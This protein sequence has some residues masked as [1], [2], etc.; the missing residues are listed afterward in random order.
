[1]VGV[2]GLGGNMNDQQTS[3]EIVDAL[4]AVLNCPRDV[5]ELAVMTVAAGGH[6]LLE[7][8]PGV[9]KTTLARA[10]AKVMAG[11]VHRVQFTPDMLPSDLTGVSI[12]DRRSENFVFRPG[13][14]FANIVI[15]DEV[16][17]ANPKTQSAMLEAMAERQISA[18]GE[19]HALP[20]PFFVVATQN[21]IELEGTYPL[22]E[23]QLDRFMTC[24]SIGY[25]KEQAEIET[26]AGIQHDDP[27]AA[28]KQICSLEDIVALRRE[29]SQVHISE[30]VARYVVSIVHATRDDAEIRFGASPRAGLALA[31]MARAHAVL[32]HRDFVVADDVRN[33]VIPVLAHR[34]VLTNSNVNSS[35]ERCKT[36]L[37]EIVN[38]IAVP[39][40]S[41]ELEGISALNGENNS[42]LRN[43]AAS[44]VLT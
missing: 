28:L 9:G 14:L 40:I 4:V 13:P 38:D 36:I 7:D 26:I 25:P 15:A 8:I 11:T 24:T 44:N 34:L 3:N 39:R 6:L 18:D 29:V 23:A 27:L 5:V 22:P 19:T 31:A 37:A 42:I 16:N 17:R 21:P 20:D 33:L 35:T 30:S 2:H 43:A 10:M 32:E 1:M 12:Y 41:D